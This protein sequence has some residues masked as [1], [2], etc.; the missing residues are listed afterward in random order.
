MSL[1]SRASLIAVWSAIAVGLGPK[2]AAAATSPGVPCS[3][4][5]RLTFEG[6]TTVTA[7]VTVSGGMLTTPAEESLLASTEYQQKFA[8]ALADLVKKAAARASGA[9]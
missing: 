4:L 1:K 7:A 5:A 6:G 3:D 8:G 9:H 2:P